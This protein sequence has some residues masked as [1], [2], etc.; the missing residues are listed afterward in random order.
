MLLVTWCA[1]GPLI[2][3]LWHESSG[4]P[5]LMLFEFLSPVFAFLAAEPSS[6]PGQFWQAL[7]LNLIVAVGMFCS[8]SVLVQKT[9]QEGRSAQRTGTPPRGVGWWRRGPTKVHR[10]WMDPNP[11]VWLVRHAGRQAE[12]IW[13]LALLASATVLLASLMGL[14]REGWV[15]WNALGSVFSFLLFVL[16]AAQ[17][18]RT[19]MDAARTV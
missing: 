17:A 2:S 19:F 10:K 1:A 18:P 3:T 8:A 7:L 14:P 13:V 15:F 12:G 11:M 6:R 5:R 16:V 9:W 4:K